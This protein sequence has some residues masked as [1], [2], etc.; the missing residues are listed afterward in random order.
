MHTPGPWETHHSHDVTGYP[1]FYIHGLSGDQKRDEAT[2]MANTRL[3]AAAPDLL[4]AAQLAESVLARGKWLDT[5]PD[6]E[7]VAL[8]ALRAAIAKAIGR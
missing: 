2:L 1:C 3:I 6:P 7:A 8:R 4:E 5:S